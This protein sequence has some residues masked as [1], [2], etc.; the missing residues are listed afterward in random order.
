MKKKTNSKKLVGAIGLEPTT[1]TMSRW[2]SNQL[3]YAPKGL[4]E[5]RILAVQNRGFQTCVKISAI[6]SPPSRRA[7]TGHIADN[8]EYLMKPA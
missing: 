8:A 7:N 3:S 5:A 6:N 1:P 2:C 4:F